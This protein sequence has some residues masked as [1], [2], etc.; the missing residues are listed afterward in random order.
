MSTLTIYT[1]GGARGNPGPAASGFVIFTESGE[2]VTEQ[3]VFIGNTT[4]NVAEYTALI[5]G[6][7]VCLENGGTNITVFSDSQLL[8]KQLNGEYKVRAPHLQP[9]YEAVKKAA[10]EFVTIKY[11][12]V[13][14]ENPG[15]VRADALV[16][17]ALDVEAQK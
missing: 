10:T 3:G 1:D 11:T 12:H 8:V 14:R 17:K 5:R 9:L 7:A 6:L 13:R 16:N 15:I 4:N 2:L